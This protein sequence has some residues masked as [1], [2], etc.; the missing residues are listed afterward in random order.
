MFLIWF[1]NF[2]MQRFIRDTKTEI[3]LEIQNSCSI[4]LAEEHRE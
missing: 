2:V 3:L 1:L 4:K